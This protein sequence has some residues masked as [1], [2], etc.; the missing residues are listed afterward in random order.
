MS[1]ILSHGSIFLNEVGSPPVCPFMLGGGNIECT[2]CNISREEFRRLS[3]VSSFVT[4][5]KSSM[6]TSCRLI[7]VLEMDVGGGD[8]E[9]SFVLGGEESTVVLS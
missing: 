1:F 8:L 3:S 5:M 9:P 4:P 7:G 6:Y 2:P